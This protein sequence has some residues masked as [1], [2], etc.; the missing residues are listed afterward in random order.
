MLKIVDRLEQD[1]RLT[2]AIDRQD[3]VSAQA[4]LQELMLGANS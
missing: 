3:A 2:G 4:I 1:N